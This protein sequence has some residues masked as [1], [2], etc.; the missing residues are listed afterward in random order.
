[1]VDWDTTRL[2]AKAAVWA[3]VAGRN[4]FRSTGMT[5]LDTAAARGTGGLRGGN[6]AGADDDEAG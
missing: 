2:L 5:I 4:G 1:M 3:A 6:G